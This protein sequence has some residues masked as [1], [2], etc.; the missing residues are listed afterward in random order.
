M[1][2]LTDPVI[3]ILMVLQ[4]KTSCHKI[5]T[6]SEIWA[7]L[8]RLQCERCCCDHVNNLAARRD[9]TRDARDAY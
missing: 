1:F 3:G 5:L 4:P 7:H 6:V 2:V 8:S 9:A